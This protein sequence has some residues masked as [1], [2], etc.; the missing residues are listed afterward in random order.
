MGDTLR[1]VTDR[2]FPIHIV[3]DSTVNWNLLTLI[4]A[5]L[6][7]IAAAIL[8]FAQK[9]YEE[10]R[11]KFNFKLYTK[12]QLGYL[13]NLVTY[14]KIDYMKPTISDNPTKEGITFVEMARRV[15]DD[16]KTHQNSIQPRI[17][18]HF[19]MNLQKYCHHIYQIR[20]CIAKIDT[21]K[22]KENILAN[23]EKLSKAEL[24]KVY[25]L[26][27]VV[28]N[29]SSI[30]LFHDRFGHLSSVQRETKN[31]IWVGFKLDKDFLSK[32]Q[33]LLE[34]IKEICNNE[35]SLNELLGITAALYN[36]VSSYYDLENHH[37]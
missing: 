9:K 35:S 20:H 36:N 32:Q 10:K 17:L 6:S 7:L 31:N 28:D 37:K 13:F 11:A 24:K 18:F 14:D 33:L 23:G 4:V 1:Y 3:D 21:A 30:S 5:M 2:P 19:I 16:F 29:F 27:V 15:R 8:P 34:D 26:L 12:E 22:L 25:G